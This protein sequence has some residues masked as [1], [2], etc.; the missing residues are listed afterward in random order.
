[1]TRAILTYSS[2]EPLPPSPYK[3]ARPYGFRPP[4]QPQKAEKKKLIADVMAVIYE[5]REYHPLAI[6]QVYYRLVAEHSYKKDEKFYKNQLC[7]V[8]TNL[9]RSRAVPMEVFRDDSTSMSYPP[10]TW[11]SQEHFLDVLRQ[12][13]ETFNLERSIGQKSRLVVWCEAAGMQPCWFST[14]RPIRAHF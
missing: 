5:Y 6:R 9:R 7:E 11:Q 10:N 12:D 13:A 1:M 14:A 8:L 4:Y 3:Y 2:T